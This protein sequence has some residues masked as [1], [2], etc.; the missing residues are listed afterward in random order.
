ML[1][2]YH[3]TYSVNRK[4]YKRY[5][6][7]YKERKRKKTIFSERKL[8]SSIRVYVLPMTFTL[9]FIKLP[10]YIAQYFLVC[11]LQN[12]SKCVLDKM[13]VILKEKS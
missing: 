1:Y 10:S 3:I 8:V 13:N 7:G 2:V 6:I 12:R 9:S 11:L 5:V 4:G